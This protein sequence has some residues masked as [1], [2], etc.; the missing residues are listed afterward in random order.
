MSHNLPSRTISVAA[1]CDHPDV[2]PPSD[3]KKKPIHGL[4]A[5]EPCLVA[6]MR[7]DDA[8]KTSSSHSARASER[9]VC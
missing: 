3:S 5:A 1:V 9:A 8:K 7:V 6:T 4:Q 2:A